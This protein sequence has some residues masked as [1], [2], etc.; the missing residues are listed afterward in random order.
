MAT[1]NKHKKAR[2]FRDYLIEKDSMKMFKEEE[3]EQAILFR[4]AYKIKDETKVFMII[5][6]DSIYITMQA[7]VMR[8]VPAEKRADFLELINT[9]QVEYPTVKYVLTPDNQL[10]TST[11]FHGTDESIQ[12]GTIMM[13]TIEYLKVLSTKHYERFEA[14]LNG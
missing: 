13:C 14:L 7:M 3:L 9:I 4:S 2:V 6:N 10:M 5:I 1:T 11:T 8:D 12:P